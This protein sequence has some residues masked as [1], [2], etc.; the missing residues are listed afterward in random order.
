[1]EEETTLYYMHIYL[2]MYHSRV[3]VVG[4]CFDYL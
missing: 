3:V 2:G 4:A 1:M